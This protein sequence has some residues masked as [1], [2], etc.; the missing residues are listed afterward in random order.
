MESKHPVLW[1]VANEHDLRRAKEELDRLNEARRRSFESIHAKLTTFVDGAVSGH[2][3]SL[4]G[5]VQ[6]I[7]DNRWHLVEI[8]TEGD[9]STMVANRAEHQAKRGKSAV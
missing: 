5:I 8:L 7:E 3:L 2:E 6:L 1:T 4:R 9:Y